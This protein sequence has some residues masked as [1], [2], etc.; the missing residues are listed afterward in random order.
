MFQHLA[1]V[2]HF[3]LRT[4]LWSVQNMESFWGY[5]DVTREVENLL[6]NHWT[7]VCLAHLIRFRQ[8]HSIPQ[9]KGDLKK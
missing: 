4:Q 5:H 2:S 9:Q 3:V 8:V 7:A 6:T 1:F